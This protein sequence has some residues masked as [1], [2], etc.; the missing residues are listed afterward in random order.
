MLLFALACTPAANLD[1][2]VAALETQHEAD[3]ARIAELEE[4]LSRLDTLLE[5]AEHVS[6]IAD[7]Q[8]AAP[9]ANAPTCTQDGETFVLPGR[10]ILTA[11]ALATEARVLPHRGSDGEFD[12]YRLTALRRDRLGDSCGLRNGDILGTV[13][14][15]PVTNPDQGLRAWQKT[16]D[17]KSFA[18]ELTRR[19][20]PVSVR[21]RWP[22]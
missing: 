8:D 6:P 14:G 16:Q 22:E 12:G 18:I 9:P 5:V 20:E 17:E 4:K 3:A 19:G 7:A 21:Y 11:E 13:A 15:L 2:R 1:A 10:D